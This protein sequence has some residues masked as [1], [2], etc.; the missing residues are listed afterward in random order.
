[1]SEETDTKP[2]LFCGKPVRN[3]VFIADTGDFYIGR[4]VRFAQG[5]RSLSG[6]LGVLGK[7]WMKEAFP[8]VYLVTDQESGLTHR[9]RFDHLMFVDRIDEDEHYRELYEHRLRCDEYEYPPYQNE[10]ESTNVSKP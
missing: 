1:M 8:G 5:D 10:T 4:E 3:A 9:A 6:R 2:C 7:L